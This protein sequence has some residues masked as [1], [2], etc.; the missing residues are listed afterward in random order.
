M[1]DLIYYLTNNVQPPIAET[2]VM[3]YVY[4]Q[5]T[6]HGDQIKE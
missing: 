5:Y 2:M 3:M 1:C 4:F 6:F